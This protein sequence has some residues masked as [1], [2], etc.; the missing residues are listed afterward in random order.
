MQIRLTDTIDLNILKIL[1]SSETEMIKR[2]SRI[3]V[4]TC[5]DDCVI[6]D[7]YIGKLVIDI[8][9]LW[10]ESLSKAEPRLPEM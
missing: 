5:L 10:H 9:N 1:I 6:H 4:S 8:C 2:P 7:S 3:H